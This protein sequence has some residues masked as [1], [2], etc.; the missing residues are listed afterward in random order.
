[1]ISKDSDKVHLL[2]EYWKYL[3]LKGFCLFLSIWSYLNFL[4]QF[5]NLWHLPTIHPH[6]KY[7]YTSKQIT[8]IYYKAKGSYVICDQHFSKLAIVSGR[9]IISD[10]TQARYVL[11]FSFNL[12]PF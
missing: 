10:S 7:F 5:Q 4:E 2:T 6:K 12:Q 1:M 9:S 3:N 8:L 11:L